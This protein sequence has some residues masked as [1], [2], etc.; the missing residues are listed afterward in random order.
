MAYGV[1]ARVPLLSV[2]LVELALQLP[3]HW[4]VREGWTKYAL[5]AAMRDRLPDEILW[6]KYKRGFEVPQRRWVEGMRIEIGKWVADL[7]LNSPF[8]GSQMLACIDAGQGGELWFWRCLS[9]VL[10]MHFSGVRW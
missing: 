10:W 3:L 5:R 2:G 7:P 4:K 6:C 8:K 1:E 9:V